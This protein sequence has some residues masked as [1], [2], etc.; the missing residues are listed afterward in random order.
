MVHPKLAR[1]AFGIAVAALSLLVACNSADDG[2]S[3]QPDGSNP[4]T[5]EPTDQT[6]DVPGVSRDEI[7]FGQSIRFAEIGLSIKAGIEAAFHEINSEG[8][9]HGRKLSLL[10]LDDQYDPAL[11]IRNMDRFIEEGEIFAV[12]G[13]SGTPTSRAVLPIAAAAGMPFIAAFTGADFIR[14][15][16]PDNVINLRPSYKQETEAIVNYLI[17]ERGYSRIALLYQD[18]AYGRSGYAGAMQAFISRGVEPIAVGLYSPNTNAIKSAVLDIA[19]AHPEG[20]LFIGTFQPFV[21]T[22]RWAN[23]VGMQTQFYTV[24]VTADKRL[25]QELGRGGAG[26]YATQ[27]FPI[28]TT[29]VEPIMVSFENALNIYDPEATADIYALEGYIAARMTAAARCRLW[30]RTE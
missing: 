17:E 29:E 24:S 6:L 20:V 28:I 21:A 9:V 25:L 26:V 14:E 23:R 22:I 3:D 12:L 19:P 11:A 15:G 18:D 8:G 13:S 5:Q 7:V 16:A 2:N 30:G 4:D 27:V 10:T 1:I